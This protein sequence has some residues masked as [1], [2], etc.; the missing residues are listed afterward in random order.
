[1]RKWA[2]LMLLLLLLAFPTIAGAQGEFGLSDL[3]IQ[4]LPEYDQPSMLVIYDFSLPTTI[5]VPANFTVRIPADA[6]LF[7]VA[8]NQNGNLYDAVYSGPEIQGDWQVINI[9]TD[10]ATAYRVEYYEPLSIAGTK[11][12]FT[13]LWPGDYAISNFKVFLSKPLDV[14]QMTTEPA[15]DEMKRASDELDGIGKSFGRLA[16]GEQF[17]LTVQYDK[18]SDALIE[19]PPELG[20]SAPVDENTPG[21]ISLSNYLPYIFGGLGL[22]LIIGG[23][24]YYW[25]S[26]RKPAS[27]PRRR[28][29]AQAEEDE[30]DAQYCPQCGTRAKPND[31]F[32]RVCGSR[33]RQES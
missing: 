21:R 23:F 14:T 19:A 11:R 1:M 15:M 17:I 7:A 27:R 28:R 30:G 6:D 31:R 29:P 13:F 2:S 18:T 32:C 10:G 12:Q 5:S 24:V 8:Y 26:G 3:S 16:K 25:Q 22:V 4:L 33:L 9:V 20:P